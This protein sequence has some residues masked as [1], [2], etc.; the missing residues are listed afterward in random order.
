MLGLD[1][2]Y[3]PGWG[4]TQPVLV[5]VD[6]GTGDPIALGHVNECDPQAVQRW[7]A[8]LVQ[9]HGI[10]VIVTDDLFCYWV[11]TD[12]LQLGHQ[13]C[14]FHI[15]R[16][17]GRSMH[18]LAAALPQEWLWV[19]DEFRALLEVLPPEGGKRLYAFWKQLPGRHSRGKTLSPLE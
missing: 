10:S 19:L 3:V 7:L 5:A 17:V 13:V 2:A 4:E 15:R 11:V 8:P 14:Q 16:W 6:L 1:G 12:K 18:D 9:Q